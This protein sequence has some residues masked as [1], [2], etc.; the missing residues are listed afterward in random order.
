MFKDDCNDC[1]CAADGLSTSCTFN[2]CIPTITKITKKNRSASN[3][4]SSKMCEPQ[5]IFKNKCNECI[6][7]ADGRTVDCSVKLCI[8]ALVIN[9]SYHTIQSPMIACQPGKSFQDQCNDCKCSDDGTRAL[10]TLKYCTAD[11]THVES[12]ETD[13]GSRIFP[14]IVYWTMRLIYPKYIWG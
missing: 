3:E 8:P 1:H 14:T 13:L 10:C 2:L 6:C 9:L 11:E 7:A 12:K 4:K 5:T